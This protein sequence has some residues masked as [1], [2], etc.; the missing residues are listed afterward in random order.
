MHQALEEREVRAVDRLGHVGP[1]HVVDDDDR[2]QGREQVPAL[3]QVGGFEV[4]DDMP[5]ELGYQ[6]NQAPVV[7]VRLGVGQAPDE[8]EADAPDA[9]RVHVGELG[10]GDAWFYRGDATGAVVGGEQR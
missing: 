6:V 1:A 8:V 5:A 10:P 3:G 2:G 9:G 4:H 7:L